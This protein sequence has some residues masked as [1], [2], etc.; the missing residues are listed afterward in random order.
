MTSGAWAMGAVAVCI[1]SAALLLLFAAFML[2]LED[3]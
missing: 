2:W 3:Q 1:I